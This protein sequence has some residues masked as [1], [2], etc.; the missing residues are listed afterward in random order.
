MTRE[1]DKPDKDRD[2]G[3]ASRPAPQR[4][5]LREQPPDTPPKPTRPGGIGG[6]KRSGPNQPK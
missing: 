5:P 2:K 6:P 1:T 3:G 4:P